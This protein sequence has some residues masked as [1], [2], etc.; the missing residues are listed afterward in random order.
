MSPTPNGERFGVST[1]GLPGLPLGATLELLGRAGYGGVELRCAPEEPVHPGLDRAERSLVARSLGRAG[2]TPIGLAGY[3]R[4]AEPGPDG[5]VLAQLR[6]E[7]WL[8]ADI[9]A[10]H[11]RVF[12][13]AGAVERDAPARARADARAARR[14]RAVASLARTCGVRVLLETH[15]SHRA[16]ADTARLLEAVGEGAGGEASGQAGALWD[17]LHTRL[18][19]DEPADAFAR[20]RPHLGYLQVKDVRAKGDPTPVMLGAGGLDPAAALA[21]AGSGGY[22]GWVVWEYEARW[23]PAAAPL[24]PMLS[25]GLAW[26]TA[27]AT[28]DSANGSPSSVQ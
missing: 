8:A 22:T 27:A 25:A 11:L 6:R 18:A 26:L 1:L 12:P 16:A 13:G 9:G 2:I 10:W 15:D 4:I 23:Y 17:V 5:P 28:A 24:A 7:I 3:V 19:G 21:A 14:L 20:L